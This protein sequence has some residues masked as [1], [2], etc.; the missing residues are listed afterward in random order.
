VCV[1]VGVV[2]SAPRGWEWHLLLLGRC[3][4][5][6]FD[7]RPASFR[8]R[9]SVH[10]GRFVY[11]YPKTE[12]ASVVF[13]LCMKYVAA[14]V[15]LGWDSVTPA[16]SRLFTWNICSITQNMRRYREQPKYNPAMDPL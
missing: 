12:E 2:G 9:P 3:E 11:D 14:G 6:F 8:L 13:I 10:S 1:R 16:I 7:R 5:A 4:H 15:L